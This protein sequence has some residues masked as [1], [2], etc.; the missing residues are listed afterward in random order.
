[1]RR[2]ALLILATA[3]APHGA[4][5]AQDNALEMCLARAA[6]MSPVYPIRVFPA[7]TSETYAGFRLPKGAS[8]K[9]LEATWTAVAN[10]AMAAIY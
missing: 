3:I 7:G 2:L 6:D 10:S 4:A 5:T 8:Y 9:E 1:V